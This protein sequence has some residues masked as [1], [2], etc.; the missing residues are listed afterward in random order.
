MVRNREMG[1]YASQSLC[2]LARHLLSFS[3]EHSLASF[4]APSDRN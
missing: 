2:Q 1:V 3:T 4:E